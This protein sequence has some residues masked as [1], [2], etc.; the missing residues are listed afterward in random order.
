M[1]P[2]HS[3]LHP[4][5]LSGFLAPIL[6]GVNSN[7]DLWWNAV[8]SCMDTL[9]SE[10]PGLLSMVRGIGLSGQML[11]PVLIDADDKPVR[12]TI[13]W[14]DGRSANK[15]DQLCEAIPDIDYRVGCRPNSGFVAPKILWL[16]KHEPHVLELI[17]CILLPKN[18]IFLKLT[19]ERVAEPTDACG[20]HLM[21]ARTG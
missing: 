11:G 21:D 13:L 19:G 8:V 18:Y 15:A 5:S 12:D 4:A 2:I 20:T 6:S 7:P 16:A 1:M 9:R 10:H 17:D 3:A 14:N